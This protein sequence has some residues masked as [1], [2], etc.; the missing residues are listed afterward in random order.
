MR[1]FK[2]IFICRFIPV[3]WTR[4]EEWGYLPDYNLVFENASTDNIKMYHVKTMLCGKLIKT[5]KMERLKLLQSDSSINECAISKKNWK[6]FFT[7]Y[8]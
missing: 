4:Q 7:K 1:P 6:Q 8:W 5:D 2:P 3:A